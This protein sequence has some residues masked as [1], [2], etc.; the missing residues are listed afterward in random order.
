[1]RVLFLFV[2]S[3]REREREREGEGERESGV[4]CK[5]LVWFRLVRLP[6]CCRVAISD[7]LLSLNNACGL[8]GFD[9]KKVAR[10]KER[11]RYT[12]FLFFGFFFF[13]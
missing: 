5:G 7:G 10:E 11:E 4:K 13:F 1:M 12:F 8:G 6:N 9:G 2:E 3:Q